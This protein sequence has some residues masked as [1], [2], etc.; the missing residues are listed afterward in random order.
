M[1]LRS[2]FSRRRPPKAFVTF[3]G[4]EVVCRTAGEATGSIPWDA[5]EQVE[6]VTTDRGPWVCDVFLV[7]RGGGHACVVPQESQ[8]FGPLLE[9][10]QALPGFDNLAVI[11]A[12]GSGEN[13]AFLCWRLPET[14][15]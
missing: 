14:Q 1:W 7:L 5:L 9:R 8:G 11:E 13:A 10:L 6:I 12:M 4:P 2:L 15:P 3:D